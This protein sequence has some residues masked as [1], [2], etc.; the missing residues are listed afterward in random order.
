MFPTNA[1]AG[2]E[3]DAPEEPAVAPTTAGAGAQVL[4][5]F[6]AGRMRLFFD[7]QGTWINATLTES[8]LYTPNRTCTPLVTAAVG[9]G[10]DSAAPT[11]GYFPSWTPLDRA[12][13]LPLITSNVSSAAAAAAAANSTT[14]NSTTAAAPQTFA[15]S[16]CQPAIGYEAIDNGAGPEWLVPLCPGQ[17]L[18]VATCSLHGARSHGGSALSLW[19]TVGAG[20]AAAGGERRM[21]SARRRRTMK[22]ATP[23]PA[24]DAS[25]NPRPTSTGTST[26]V[27][28]LRL[29]ERRCFAGRSLTP[30]AACGGR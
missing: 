20:A 11:P 6:G 21:A 30:C 13:G 1:D 24:A 23:G 2:E 4:P 7:S 27:S 12:T 9:T 3:K 29:L 18:T 16:F 5:G 8:V 10:P 26:L 19:T 17:T 14:V 15:S 28:S 22:Q 25:G